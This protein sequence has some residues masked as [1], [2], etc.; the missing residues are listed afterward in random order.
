MHVASFFKYKNFPE[1]TKGYENISIL[2][3][4][5]YFAFLM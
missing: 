5:D 4:E 3:N 2:A 1:T